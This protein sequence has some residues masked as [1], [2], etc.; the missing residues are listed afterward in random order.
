MNF[1]R[2]FRRDFAATLTPRVVRLLEKAGIPLSSLRG[3]SVRVR[4][5]V[6]GWRAPAIEIV[7]AGQIEVVK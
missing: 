2:D 1:G 4:G 6:G 3:K 5:M 7:S